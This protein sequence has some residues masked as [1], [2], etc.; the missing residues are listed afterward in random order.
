LL[1]ETGNYQKGD[2][3]ILGDGQFVKEVLK[4]SEEKLK[5]KIQIQGQ[6][7]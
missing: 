5:E 7:L 6:R 3:R 2:E 1:R 4:K